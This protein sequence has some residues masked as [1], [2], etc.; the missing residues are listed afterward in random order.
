MDEAAENRNYLTHRM[1]D[2]IN[3]IIRV[4]QLT[5][6]DEDEWESDDLTRIKKAYVSGTS[7]E[8][9]EGDGANGGPIPQNTI[10][11]N[12]SLAHDW[13]EDPSAVT[14]GVGEKSVRQIVE[15][16]RRVADLAL[17]ED[18]EP[19]R[20]MASDI[21][22]MV[23][24][25]C[26]LRDSGQG[27]TPQAQSLGRG[28]NNKVKELSNLV[29][30]AILNIERSGIQG[31]AHTVPGRLE[32]ASKWLSNPNI[33][34]KGVGQQAIKALV[35]DGRKIGQSCSPPQREDI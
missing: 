18:K 26:E 12:L 30:R 29:N 22:S 3:E 6:Y 27:D 14:G 15:N 4:L 1:S 16:A 5:T 23:N 28:I 8:G 32:Q 11:G 20:K 21:E 2:E 13:L 33:D 7:G 34:D 17:P 25:L 19:I 31:P 24:G 9:E 35:Q 10:L